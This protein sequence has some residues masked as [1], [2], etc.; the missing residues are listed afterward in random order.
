MTYAQLIIPAKLSVTDR[1]LRKL[2]EK[3]DSLELKGLIKN[4]GNSKGSYF[5]GPSNS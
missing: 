5:S 3:Y 1:N 4:Y 2:A